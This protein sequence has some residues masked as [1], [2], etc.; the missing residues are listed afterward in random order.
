[1]TFVAILLCVSNI[2]YAIFCKAENTSNILTAASGWVS[3]LATALL[4]GI[5]L[6]QNKKYKEENEKNNKL[7]SEMSRKPEIYYDNNYNCKK[8]NDIPVEPHLYYIVKDGE[9]YFTQFRLLLEIMHLPVINFRI[10]N[11]Q[12]IDE[13]LG[14]THKIDYYKGHGEIKCVLRESEMFYLQF[15][16]EKKHVEKKLKVIIHCRYNNIYDENFEKEIFIYIDKGTPKELKFNSA[17]FIMG[18]NKNG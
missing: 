2:M 9:S 12:L 6:A 17:N 16:I 10:S 1:M 11:I 4:G 18:D 7:I 15:H 5:A 14:I 8:V 13:E 3:G